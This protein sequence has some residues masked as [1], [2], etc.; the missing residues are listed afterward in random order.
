[1][2]AGT[3]AFYRA[4]RC[5][6]AGVLSANGNSDGSRQRDVSEPPSTSPSVKTSSFSEG[7]QQQRQVQAAQQLPVSSAGPG[8]PRNEVEAVSLSEGSQQQRQVQAAQQVS[9]SSASPAD[10]RKLV[11]AVTSQRALPW[12]RI[13]VSIISM[14]LALLLLRRARRVQR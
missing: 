6:A 1:M 4:R 5:T 7:S 12:R 2:G 3:C 11:V 14:L 13:G 9:V 10:P 8:D